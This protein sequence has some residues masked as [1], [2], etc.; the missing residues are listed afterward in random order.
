[1]MMMM[2]MTMM[3]M[4][5]II[6]II[7]I[8]AIDVVIFQ[9]Y[10]E[11]GGHAYFLVGSALFSFIVGFEILCDFGFSKLASLLQRKIYCGM[12]EMRQICE[13]YTRI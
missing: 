10:R 3:M 1:M 2:M 9:E 4:I 6:I 5:I 7:I 12:Q 11:H 13:L 8:N